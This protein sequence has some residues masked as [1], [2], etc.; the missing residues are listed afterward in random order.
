MLLHE[1]ERA[2]HLD[3]VVLAME[4]VLRNDAW[5]ACVYNWIQLSPE[6]HYSSLMA[7]FALVLTEF[8]LAVRMVATALVKMLTSNAGLNCI[9][10]YPV[11][12]QERVMGGLLGMMKSEVEELQLQVRSSSRARAPRGAYECFGGRLL[13]P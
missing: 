11:E 3:G 4:Q 13:Q 6:L 1:P 2:S 5:K 12:T 7:S 10:R 8:P 9:V